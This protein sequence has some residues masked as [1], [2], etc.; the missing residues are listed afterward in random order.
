MPIR[1]GLIFANPE[2]SCF[3]QSGGVLFLP[4]RRGPIFANPDG[5]QFCQS[6]RVLFLPIRRGPI[7]PIRRGPIFV[8]PEGIVLSR[9]KK[10]TE[11]K[12]VKGVRLLGDRLG[13]SDCT[14]ILP[15]TK[16]PSQNKT[17]WC[18]LK[19][20]TFLRKVIALRILVGL[21]RAVRRQIGNTG[22]G[23]CNRRPL[24]K[25]TAFKFCLFGAAPSRD[26]S[27]FRNKFDYCIA[28]D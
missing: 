23:G 12:V 16:K 24:E 17:H 22:I 26:S 2:G 3:Y 8:N 15:F 11:K 4:I 25:I 14:G 21:A 13:T 10:T 28:T 19:S 9:L 6:G 20:K 27:F 7:L 18:G 1:K 5:S